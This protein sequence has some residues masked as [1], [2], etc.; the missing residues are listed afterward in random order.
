M[1]WGVR[2]T[3]TSDWINKKNSTNNISRK[4]CGKN[5]L[6]AEAKNQP[7]LSSS[8]YKETVF[9][10]IGSRVLPEKGKQICSSFIEEQ[11]LPVWRGTWL[12]TP[13]DHNRGERAPS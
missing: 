7:D 1:V 4:P 12:F 11:N 9:S 3:Q 2:L 13:A 6:L 5:K 8:N 10:L